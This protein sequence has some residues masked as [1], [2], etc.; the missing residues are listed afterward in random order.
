MQATAIAELTDPICFDSY[1]RPQIWGGRGLSQHLGR[2]LP[3]QGS[4]GEAWEISALPPHVSRVSQGVTAGLELTELWTHW[5]QNLLG[6]EAGRLAEPTAEFPLLVK[7]LECRELLS[8]QVHPDD[9]M[10]REVLGQP[11]GKSEAWIVIHAEPTARVFAGL[12]PGVTRAEFVAH[13]T[14]GTVVKCLHSFVPQ[15]GDCISLPAGTV[16][17]AGGGVVLAEVQQSSDATFRL[18][19]WH[20]LGLDGKPRPLQVDQAL[21]AIDWHQGAIQPLA[22]HAMTSPLSGVYAERLLNSPSFVLER[23]TIRSRLPAPHCGELTIWMVLD[24]ETEL[25]NPDTGYRQT[26]SRGSSVLIP[27]VTQDVQWIPLPS[28]GTATLLCIRLRESAA[29]TFP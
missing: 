16:H 3:E 14:A 26:F 23:F 6:P 18:F 4:Y 12:K 27:A 7:W 2:T 13:L 8:V 17:A 11:Y 24:G 20:R 25:H 28:E 15:A 29:E 5:R 21:Q 9:S 19:D 22:P 1:L 10:A